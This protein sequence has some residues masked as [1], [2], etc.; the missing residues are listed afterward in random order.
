MLIPTNASLSPLFIVPIFVIIIASLCSLSN[1]F[2]DFCNGHFQFLGVWQQPSSYF[3]FIHTHL[4]STQWLNCADYCFRY[5]HSIFY[6]FCYS[7]C[8]ASSCMLCCCIPPPPPS[9][10]VIMIISSNYSAVAFYY[11]GLIHPCS[12]L[13]F[14]WYFNCSLFRGCDINNFRGLLFSFFSCA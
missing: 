12:V 6:F 5:V 13:F 8:T 1:R 4:T 14:I 3:F 9:L 7:F 2:W 10:I 11:W